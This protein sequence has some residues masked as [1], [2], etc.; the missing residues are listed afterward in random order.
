MG[1]FTPG[2]YSNFGRGVGGGA[3]S[4]HW[5][6]SVQV[7]K[8]AIYRPGVPVEFQSDELYAEPSKEVYSKV[9]TEKTD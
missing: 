4:A 7:E 6:E 5:I 3:A 8:F 9:K 1:Y 2:Y